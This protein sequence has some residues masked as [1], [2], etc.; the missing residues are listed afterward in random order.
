MRILF[1]RE[2]TPHAWDNVEE[3]NER[4]HRLGKGTY[5]FRALKAQAFE[6]AEILPFWI[7]TR[8]W[9]RHNPRSE[10]AAIL[11]YAPEGG[12]CTFA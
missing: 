5:D 11:H 6:T 3:G 2:A 4:R 12:S 10:Q 1:L 8:S 7:Q 9:R